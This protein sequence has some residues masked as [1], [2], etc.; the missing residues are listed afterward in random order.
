MRVVQVAQHADDLERAAGWYQRLLGRP[1]TARFDPPGL[2]FFSLDGTRLLLE[3]GAPSAL[4]YLEVPDLKATVEALR[5]DGVT[6][7]GEPQLIFHHDDDRLGPAGTDEWMA[8]VQDSEGNT[9]G[10]VGRSGQGP[11]DDAG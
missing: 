7:T 10:L 5:S 1:P 9:V 3:S 6:I 2:L 4:I 8:F 11:D